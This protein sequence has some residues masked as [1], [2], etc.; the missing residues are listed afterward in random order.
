MFLPPA[1]PQ[2]DQLGTQDPASRREP[3]CDTAIA[4]LSTVPV[5]VPDL[6][7]NLTFGSALWLSLAAFFAATAVRTF[8]LQCGM[9]RAG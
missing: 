8:S 3:I 2:A 7:S 1:A 6:T 9:G 4:V 5:R